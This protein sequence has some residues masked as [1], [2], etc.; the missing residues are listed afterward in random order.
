MKN[1]K[2]HELLDKSRSFLLNKEQLEKIYQEAYRDWKKK[3]PG[4]TE[5]DFV[6]EEIK[7]ADEVIKPFEN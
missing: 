4:K 6:K 2:S 5:L 1:R 3:N 7:A